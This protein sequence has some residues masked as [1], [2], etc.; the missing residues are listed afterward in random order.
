MNRVRLA[1]LVI[2]LVLFSVSDGSAQER[3]SRSLRLQRP[4]SDSSLTIVTKV[5]FNGRYYFIR[6]VPVDSSFHDPMPMYNSRHQPMFLWRDSLQHLL[7]DS[8]LKLLPRNR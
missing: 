4:P 2:L 3:S 5:P 7:P 1:I 6:I 8:L